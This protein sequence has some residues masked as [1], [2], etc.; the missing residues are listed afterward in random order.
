MEQKNNTNE[1]KTVETKT[2]SK[3]KQDGVAVRNTIDK[4]TVV[5]VVRQ[6]MHQKYGKFVRKTKRYLVHDE[7]GICKEGDV[8]RIISTRPLSKRKCWKIDSILS[9]VAS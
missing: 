2:V 4:T 8:V 5:Q 3:K 9:S 6:V 7:N 1:N